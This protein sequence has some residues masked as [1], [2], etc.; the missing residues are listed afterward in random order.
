MEFIAWLKTERDSRPISDAW[1]SEI[2]D[3][4]KELNWVYEVEKVLACCY[5]IFAPGS[6]TH[7]STCWLPGKPLNTGP[8]LLENQQNVTEVVI[9]SFLN[10]K[11]IK[12]HKYQE[13]CRYRNKSKRAISVYCLQCWKILLL[14]GEALSV[15]VPFNVDEKKIR[16]I[17]VN[18]HSFKYSSQ[19]RT[20]FEYHN[21]AKN[22]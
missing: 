12:V 1:I 5:M 8:L 4:I 9:K 11:S 20:K 18:Y 21:F 3:P 19:G 10:N 14:S 6:E 15:T 17:L 22:G 13:P 16:L 7:P 2:G